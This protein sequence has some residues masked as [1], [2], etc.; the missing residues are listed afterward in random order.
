MDQTPR[1]A[2]PFI[3]SGQAQKHITHN[4]A[5]QTLDV[6]VQASVESRTLATPPTTP[7]QGESFLVPPGAT[8]AWAGHADELASFQS[9]AWLL[10]DPSPGWQLYCK[11]DQ[12]LLVF[13]G[14]AW[15]PLAALGSGLPRLGVNT[16]A[17]DT[18]RLA[19]ASEASLFTHIGAGHQLKLNKSTPADT[20]SLLFQTNWSGR[21]EMGLAGDDQ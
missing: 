7:L 11:A 14:A 9:G 3:I 21:A 17:D 8:G 6:L 20:A 18:N 5:L 10:L 13:D 12:T 15:L 2:L 16:S 4:E 19:V 1:L